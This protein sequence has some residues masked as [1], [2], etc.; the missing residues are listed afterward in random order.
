MPWSHED[1]DGVLKRAFADASKT[2]PNCHFLYSRFMVAK[3]AG[4]AVS[5]ACGF[6]YPDFG[7]QRSK[8]GI[9]AALLKHAAYD[10]PESAGAGWSNLSFFEAALPADVEYDNTWMIEVGKRDHC[11]A[12]L[13][14]IGFYRK[15]AS[16]YFAYVNVKYFNIVHYS[17]LFTC[18][19]LCNI[20]FIY[21]YNCI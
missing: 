3:T 15:I 21:N 10:S 20:Y 7:V 6:K 18:I 12:R 14:T 1:H 2:D 13:M 11:S 17:P 9:L 5:A 8:E 19:Y 16:Y 4:K